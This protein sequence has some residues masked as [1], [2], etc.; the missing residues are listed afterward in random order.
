MIAQYVYNSYDQDVWNQSW[1]LLLEYGLSNFYRTVRIQYPH[2]GEPAPESNA[3]N[4]DHL[5]GL[6]DV[7]QLALTSFKTIED[8]GSLYDITNRSIVDEV[9]RVVEAKKHRMQVLTIE[10][11]H[12]L[13]TTVRLQKILKN[14]QDTLRKF[15]TTMYWY[16]DAISIIRTPRFLDLAPMFGRL[17]TLHLH[18]ITHEAINEVA[19]MVD[20]LTGPDSSLRELSLSYSIFWND[21]ES[22]MDAHFLGH[23]NWDFLGENCRLT[24]FFLM[25][26]LMDHAHALAFVE[27]LTACPDLTALGIRHLVFLESD[28]W[29]TEDIEDVVCSK[30]AV[31]SLPSRLRTL[32]LGLGVDAMCHLGDPMDSSSTVSWPAV[33]TL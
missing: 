26:F 13:L 17:T 24:S 21:D 31:S 7:T 9:I 18:A 14:V 25:G 19:T 2:S 16:P 10:P 11:F 1:P 15:S 20:R 23:N 32:H 3:R 8:A 30:L 4:I 6:S 27:Q 29:E 22:D 12:C 5:N 33:E 28:V